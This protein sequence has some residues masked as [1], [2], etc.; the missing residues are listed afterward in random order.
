MTPLTAGKR[1]KISS[2]S[3][4]LYAVRTV[5]LGV[6]ITSLRVEMLPAN[7]L[8]IT[9]KQGLIM[10]RIKHQGSEPRLVSAGAGSGSASSPER[11]KLSKTPASSETSTDSTRTCRKR[12][13]A[14][15]TQDHLQIA[16]DQKLWDS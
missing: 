11:A 1:W 2:A 13:F 12:D 7:S 6:S 14:G 8:S 10:L 3:L 16:R 5:N 9:R 15:V 4:P